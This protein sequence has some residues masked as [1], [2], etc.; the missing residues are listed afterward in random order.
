MPIFIWSPVNCLKQ[1]VSVSLRP[2]GVE[3]LLNIMPSSALRSATRQHP[4][5]PRWPVWRRL[6]ATAAN[7]AA[8]GVSGADALRS[9][10]CCTWRQWREFGAIR[11]LKLF[12]YGR[13]LVASTP[14]RC[15]P[16]ACASCTLFITPCF[17]ARL[18]GN[19]L[20]WRPQYQLFLPS[21]AE[22]QHGCC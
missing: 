1:A 19:L 12:T 18:A 14:S 15:S 3:A 8:A 7:G 11:P 5:S 10:A 4:R 20:R 6:T 13:A 2:M 22:L 17:G 9:G 16:P 21:G